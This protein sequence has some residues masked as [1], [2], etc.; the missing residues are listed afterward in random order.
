[1]FNVVISPTQGFCNRLRAIASACIL[2]ECLWEANV[3]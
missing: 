1:M 2:S 3:L